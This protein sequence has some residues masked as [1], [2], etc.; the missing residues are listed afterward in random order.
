[1]NSKME[2]VFQG[3]A[4]WKPCKEVCRCNT[5]LLWRRRRP[6]FLLVPMVKH[7][8]TGSSDICLNTGSAY[9]AGS[10]TLDDGATTQF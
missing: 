8:I 6:A 1:M 7:E 3:A 9:K 10:L 4:E 5:H 2:E